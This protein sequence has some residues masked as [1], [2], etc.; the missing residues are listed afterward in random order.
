MRSA[1]LAALCLLA[2][3]C[4]GSFQGGV[5]TGKPPAPLKGAAVVVYDRATEVSRAETGA[6]GAFELSL[7]CRSEQY[8]VSVFQ[9]PDDPTPSVVDA[10]RLI[11]DGAVKRNY[12]LN[13]R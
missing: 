7:P 11:G 8:R 3:C 12:V 6:D 5:Y 1:S 10:V 9:S 4:S 2:G 13:A